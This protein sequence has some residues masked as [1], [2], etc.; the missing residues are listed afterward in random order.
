[1]IGFINADLL[2]ADNIDNDRCKKR[3]NSASPMFVEINIDNDRFCKQGGIVETAC[4]IE[5]R[6]MDNDRF[7]QVKKRMTFDQLNACTIN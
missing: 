6:N 1:M 7:L 4:R 3:P 5:P 2:T